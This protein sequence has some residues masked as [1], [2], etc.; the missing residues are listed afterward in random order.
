M[1]VEAG[2]KANE[3]P[4][5]Q[6]GGQADEQNNQQPNNSDE[7]NK[8]DKGDSDL[9]STIRRIVNEVLGK[10]GVKPAR[11]AD[12]STDG[13]RGPASLRR[14]EEEAEAAVRKAAERF[15]KDKEHEEQH[16]KLARVA[17]APPKE[18]GKAPL[19][20]RLLWGED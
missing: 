8:G 4:G 6:S 1:T 14:I 19:L 18:K 10:P 11:Q 15:Q 16:K 12:N 3:K 13:N 9:E 7:G 20:Q 17:E 2:E 5:E